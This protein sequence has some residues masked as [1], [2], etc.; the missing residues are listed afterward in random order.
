MI[1]DG[2]ICFEQTSFQLSQKVMQTG[3]V[4]PRTLVK[5]SRDFHFVLGSKKY[6]YFPWAFLSDEDYSR[7][8]KEITKSY[9]AMTGI[10]HLFPFAACRDPARLDYAAFFSLIDQ[11]GDPLTT[12]IRQLCLDYAAFFSLIDQSG[13]PMVYTFDLGNPHWNRYER[14][15]FDD[16]LQRELADYNP[17]DFG[18]PQAYYTFDDL[19]RSMKKGGWKGKP[20]DV[21]AMFDGA[22]ITVDNARVLAAREAKVELQAKVHRYDEPLHRCEMERF[23]VEGKPLPLTWGE[24]VKLRI[25]R[26]NKEWR[27]KFP[28]GSLVAP[29]ITGKDGEKRENPP[30]PFLQNAF[31]LNQEALNAG[32]VYPKTLIK[33]SQNVSSVIDREK[34]PYFPWF[35]KDEEMRIRYNY[36][37]LREMIKYYKRFSKVDS[38]FCF[39]RNQDPAQL[40]YAVCFSLK[41][42]TGN[43]KVYFFDLGDES[44]KGVVYDNFD[45]W[46]QRELDYYNP[47][48]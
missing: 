37:S 48:S 6:P 43:P 46:L 12:S 11:S 34:Y 4:Y 38:L 42:K 16:W 17:E 31:Q 26:Q 3:F 7:P 2:Q 1:E 30:V 9:K 21:V 13:D 24:A 23:G 36:L 25:S 19:V 28:N 8:L 14:Y 27:G 35:F 5:L 29:T 39:A 22:I 45:V 10:D 15:S 20:A 18:E 32:M 47:Q 41:D 44:F 40:D 33:L